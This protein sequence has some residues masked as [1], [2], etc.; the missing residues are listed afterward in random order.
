MAAVT[1]ESAESKKP[2][3]TIATVETDD[4]A[5]DVHRPD[6]TPRATIVL[7]HGAGGNRD[8]IILRALADELSSRGYVVARIDLPYRRRRPKGPPS[9][10]T[11]PAD[12]DGIRAA[13][14]MFREES[15]GPLFVGGH[16]YGGRQ[17]SM[18]VAEDGTDLADGLLLTSYPLH[19]PGKPDRLRTEHLPSI[20]V[21]TLVVHGSTDPFGTA[22][23]MA[24][25]IGLIDAPTRIV[26][27]EKVG[28]DLNPKKKPTA[29]LT[30]DAVDEFLM[31]A[32]RA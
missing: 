3:T 31:K 28:H 14:A 27:L 16:S 20:T 17:A 19:P 10:S 24:E 2:G 22:E 12:R 26:E 6:G 18:A 21:P 1:A 23:E 9:P 5:A 4:V 13:C 32:F 30:A 15:D 7:A 25:A 8:A 29:Q 11:S